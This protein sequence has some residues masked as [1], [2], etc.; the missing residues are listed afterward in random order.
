MQVIVHFLADYTVLQHYLIVAGI[1]LTPAYFF[2]SRQFALLVVPDYIPFSFCCSNQTIDPDKYLHFSS[3]Y[4]SK[5]TPAERVLGKIFGFNDR[6]FLKGKSIFL[7]AIK[8]KIS[9]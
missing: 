5:V 4:S 3:N 7:W 9:C 1:F 2:L 6:I 8:L